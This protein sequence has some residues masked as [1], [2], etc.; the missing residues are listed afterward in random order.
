MTRRDGD[1]VTRAL[2]L[3]HPKAPE[4]EVILLIFIFIFIPIGLFSFLLVEER[5][6]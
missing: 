3:I 5:V 4:F 6:M 2:E 1:K